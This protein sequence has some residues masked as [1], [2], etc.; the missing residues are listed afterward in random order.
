[1]VANFIKLTCIYFIN[2]LRKTS[3]LQTWPGQEA[4][5]IVG[6]SCIWSTGNILNAIN[7]IFYEK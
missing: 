4:N 2:S 1:M 3:Y 7:Q 6:D 5:I